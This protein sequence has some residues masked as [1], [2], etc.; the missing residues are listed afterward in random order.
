MINQHRGLRSEQRIRGYS[1][2]GCVNLPK[3]DSFQGRVQFWHA[4]SCAA[5]A[6]ASGLGVLAAATLYSQWCV[7]GH[8]DKS[9]TPQVSTHWESRK[10][11]QS[12][13]NTLGSTRLDWPA[14]IW[15]TCSARLVAVVALGW[16]NHGHASPNRHAP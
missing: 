2:R 1:A 16:V 7:D 12:P 6:C 3:K 10:I 4:K 9:R 8:A 11:N 14:R 15:S 5:I 13:A